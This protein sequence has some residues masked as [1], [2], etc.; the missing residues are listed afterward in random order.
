MK[1]IEYSEL[2]CHSSFSLLD[3]ASN[4]E[5]LVERANDLG[6]SALA[7]TDH[8]DLGGIVRFTQKAQE[9]NFDI[10]TGVELTLEDNSHII[11]LAK[12]L[13]GYKNICGLTTHARSTQDRGEPRVPYTLLAERAKGLVAL[14]G[15]PRG[16]IPSSLAKED[17]DAAKNHTRLLLE[18]FGNDFYLELW[19]HKLKQEEL[20]CKQ[21][22]ELSKLYKIPWVVT[23]NVHYALPEQRII[24]DVLTCTR[25][26]VTISQ[27]GKRLRPNGSWYL[28]SPREIAHLWRSNLEGV[29]NTLL[30]AEKCQFRLGMLNP[31]L[32]DIYSERKKDYDKELKE[33]VFAGASKRYGDELTE[34]HRQQIAHELALIK[35]LRV[36][37]F[38]LIMW[39]VIQFAKKSDIAVQGRG[40]AA[41]SAVCY[42]L[43]ITAVD[44][45]G[46]DLL[47][48]RFLSKERN[49]PPD[50]DL[51][52]AH[53]EREKVIQYIYK[54]YG[55]KHAAM[56]CEA[57]TYRGRSAVRDAARVLEFSQEKID[58]LAAQSHFSEAREA[59]LNLANGGIEKA[60]LD[61]DDKRVKLLIQ[62]VS[63]LNKLPRH[64][65][66]HV[67]GFVLSGEPV[68]DIVPVEP[69]SMPGRT[70]VQ[71]DK[72]DLSA[73]G[74]IKIDFLGLGML[75]MLQ[76]GLK[77]IEK[78]HGINIDIGQIDMND[79]SIYE[80]MAKA[81]TIGVFQIESRAQMSILPKLKPTRF[82]DIVVSVA[83]VRPGP[84]Q[85]NIVHPYIRRRR[86]LEKVD[87]VHPSFEPILKRTLGVP[88]FQEQGMRLAIVAANFTAAEADKLRTIMSHKRSVEKM[89]ELCV[90]LAEG[91]KQNGLS[92][93]AIET[94]THQLR[95][96]A[97]YGFPESHAASFAKLTYASAYLK[98]YYP[99]EFL[100][101]ILNS[102]PMGF[103]SPDTLIRDAIRH[104]IKVTSP[105]L[106]K[107]EWDCTL[108]KEK[109][110]TFSV[111]LGLRY[112]KGLGRRAK[113]SLE[114]S[115]SQHGG[116]TS[117]EDVCVRSGLGTK[118][119][120]LLA[121]AGAFDTFL[122][123]RRRALWE[124]LS[125]LRRK[126]TPLLDYL[127]ETNN[128]K[129]IEPQVNIRP[130]TE[131]NRVI[132]DYKTQDLTTRDHPMTFYRA[133]ARE[134][135]IDSCL[136]L[137]EGEHDSY[138][139]VA[140]AVIC[141]QKPGTAK[142]FVFLTLEDETGLANIIV[143]PKVFKR[144]KSV[145]I[146]NSFLAV[147]GRLQIDQGVV[148]VIATNFK[149]LPDLMQ[150]NI[151]SH[152][153]H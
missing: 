145:I 130:M 153:F 127:A 73:A 96:F 135:K 104:G 65:S 85:G 148:N 131:L 102:Q 53:Q 93:K 91:M 4:P 8:S 119:L 95:A 3:G 82:Y 94:I 122:P 56:V 69:A 50:I 128:L 108:E 92:D 71:W 29:K 5:D 39:D 21:M 103:Y 27:A 84:I 74:I 76:K 62:V 86:G 31:P 100:C 46:M 112:I 52:I 120:R 42:C 20:I 45:I 87:Y 150:L 89:N 136:Q 17:I 57:I 99:A 22:L 60:G 64:R 24:H 79:Q 30:V 106:A 48:E 132:A 9:I 115:W 32:P 26:E 143:R 133:W 12:D 149:P 40:S 111:R 44:P 58:L 116:F 43:Y 10:I 146:Q 54:K 47:F 33:L 34:R 138:L 11:L 152:D 101:A 36:A 151:R 110:G 137:A 121:E 105:D 114:E 37:P 68:G 55:H 23:N 141:R 13:T 118:S 142:D 113:D 61:P 63:G 77:L 125:I 28:K 144:F 97:H 88:L 81:D 109:D 98:R 126:P 51:D 35:E 14:S 41:N 117:I 75:T 123:D 7:L 6:L 80:M 38:F 59:A 18:I 25:H 78:H 2:H 19:N 15:C 83:I 140:G 16:A 49:E 67:G 147:R 90:K 129:E 72:D 1:K 70:V 66:I 124:V 139:T 107:S 134:H